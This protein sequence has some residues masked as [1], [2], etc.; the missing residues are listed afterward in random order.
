MGLPRSSHRTSGRQR[1]WEARKPLIPSV[2]RENSAG[3]LLQDFINIQREEFKRLGVMGEWDNPYLTM[4]YDYEATIAREFGRFV[5]KG[6][7]Y[8]GKKPVY[9]CASCETALAEA[10]VEYEDH[11]SPSITVKFPAL[12]DFGERFPALK[13]KKVYVLIW[14]TTPWTIPANLAIAFHPDYHLCGRGSGRGGLDS[15][16][17]P[18]RTGHGP[19]GKEANTR[20]WPNFPARR[21]RDSRSAIPS[22]TGNPFSSWPITSLWTQGP[23]PCTPLPATGRKTTSRASSTTFPFTLRWMT[24]AVS[25]RDVQFF[26]GQYRLR[27]QRSRHPETRGGGRL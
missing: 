12:S 18:S 5:G 8:R 13:G 7:V 11:K 4:S 19:G 22:S 23:G 10:E 26:A 15:G 14:T 21:S 9:W 16:R 6:S 20:S 24:R 3:R 2:R 27:R 1:I 17:S 25:L